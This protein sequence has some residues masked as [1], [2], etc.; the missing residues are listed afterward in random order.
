MRIARHPID[1]RILA[2]A[3]PALGALL[4]E[5]LFLATD[6]AMIGHL[7]AVPLA[8]I[9]IA[10]TV[11]HTVVGLLVFLAYATTP[12]VA[13]RLGAGD[14]PGAIRAGVD[15]LWLAA[16]IGVVLAIAGVPGAHPLA[17]A[18]G[19]EEAVTGQA[20]SYLRI[21]VL[22]LPAML[23]VIAA[24][25]LFRGLQDTRTPLVV[26]VTG[27]GA[28]AALNAVLIY[29]LGWGIVGSAVGT[30]VA[31]LGMAVACLVIAVRAAR[32]AGVTL[33]PGLRGVSGSAL[34]GG[35]LLLRTA[36]LRVALV[37]TTVVAAE[38]GTTV[39]GATHVLL[40]LYFT[41]ALALD[42]FAIAGQALVGHGLGAADAPGVRAIV[43]RLLGWGL[44]TSLALGA[45]VAATSPVLGRVFTQDAAVLAVLPAGLL[46]LALAMPIAALVFV[47]DGVLIGAG[48][49][50]YLA[51]TGILNLAAYL[52]LLLLGSRLAA[53]PLGTVVAI[54]L[55]FCVGYLSARAMTLAL[56]TRGERWMVIGS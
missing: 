6:T 34:A 18:F 38:A 12:T 39:L 9:G 19:A 7:G 43:R 28:N 41:V 24:T 32:G 46:V 53:D 27:F 26:A 1:R 31:Q 50:R 16:G 48:D 52:P 15:G 45:L 10:S 4:A 13:R 35:W 51:W 56:R 55:A 30:V 17:A 40:T 29:G 54:Q 22:G 2:L 44:G 25:G 37:A 8:G 49:V 47:L 11:L 14:R 23:V 20:A 42:A 5:P 36:S 33:R 21:A 3:V